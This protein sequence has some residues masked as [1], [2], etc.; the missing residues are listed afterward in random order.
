MTGEPSWA[1]RIL[2]ELVR[3]VSWTTRGHIRGFL[4][5]VGTDPVALVMFLAVVLAAWLSAP[6]AWKTAVMFGRRINRRL[7]A[8]RVLRALEELVESFDDDFPADDPAS[9]L[10]MDDTVRISPYTAPLPRRATRRP[11][12]PQRPMRRHTSTSRRHK[13]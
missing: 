5:A 3:V 8:R 12:F 10:H 7:A 4:L 11:R 9:A 1:V 6:L 2:A 13:P